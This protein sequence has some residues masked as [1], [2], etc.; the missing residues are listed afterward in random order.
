M[1]S[2]VS[3]FGD[4]NLYF[5]NQWF[6]SNHGFHNLISVVAVVTFKVVV[7]VEL[8]VV[9]INGFKGMLETKKKELGLCCGPYFFS[10]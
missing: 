9:V 3:G 1:V 7:V 2:K 5:R 4:Y 8:Q 10:V 6:Q